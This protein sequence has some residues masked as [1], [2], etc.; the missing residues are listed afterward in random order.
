MHEK[1]D[2]K[3]KCLCFDYTFTSSGSRFL[4]YT[5]SAFKTGF[6]FHDICWAPVWGTLRVAGRWAKVRWPSTLLRTN[7][8]SWFAPF[9][10]IPTT[11]LPP[12]SHHVISHK[13]DSTV[14]VESEIKNE[15]N[16]SKQICINEFAAKCAIVVFYSKNRWIIYKYKHLDNCWNCQFLRLSI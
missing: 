10:K 4:N 12:V 16:W 15:I 11:G 9:F 6:L 14:W 2:S 13:N 3:K 8:N 7:W 5:L 1:K